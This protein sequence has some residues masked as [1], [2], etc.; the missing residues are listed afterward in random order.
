[1]LLDAHYG[2]SSSYSPALHAVDAGDGDPSGDGAYAKDAI[3][4]LAH[5]GA[6]QAVVGSSS[7]ISGGPL[8]HPV[9][10]KSLNVLGSLVIDVAGNRLDARMI[11]VGGDVLDHFQIVK[12]PALPACSNG[13]DDDGDGAVDFPADPG[14]LLGLAS[15]ENPKCDDDV[16]NDG[17]GAIDWDG[18][19]GGGTPDPSCAGQGSR[20]REAPGCGVGAELVLAL[21]LLGRRRG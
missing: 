18:G 13:S 4:P 5:A 20:N 8:N 2:A 17:D 15:A 9:M 11:G 14:C 10:V 12:G 7:Q 21:A 16:D 6:V 1:V 3:G 19:M